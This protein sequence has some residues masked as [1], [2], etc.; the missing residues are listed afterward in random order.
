M[1]RASS[2]LRSRIVKPIRA[3]ISIVFFLLFFIVNLLQSSC[4]VMCVCFMCSIRY[5]N[6][7]RIRESAYDRPMCP[8]LCCFIIIILCVFVECLLHNYMDNLRVVMGIIE[9]YRIDVGRETRHDKH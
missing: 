8:Y 6:D 5:N 9:C 3:L 4:R 1:R 2:G 7:Y